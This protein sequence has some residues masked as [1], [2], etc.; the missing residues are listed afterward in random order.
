[1]VLISKSDIDYPSETNPRIAGLITTD[2]KIQ[3]LAKSIETNGLLT[4]VLLYK[5]ENG[6][7][8]AIDGDRRLLALFDV[9]ERDEVDATIK[10]VPD[11]SRLPYLK[12]ASNW[13]RQDFTSIEKGRYL[14]TIVGN[15]M[16]NDNFKIEENW[17]NREIRNEYVRKVS[18]N[19][20]RP[21]ST[22]SR[23]ISLWLQVPRED[24]GIIA[25]NRDELRLG[26]LAPHK[27]TKILAIG[28][29]IG[30]VK[31]TWRTFV[32]ENAVNE[33]TPLDIRTKELGLINR[34]V[35]AGQIKGVSQLQTFRNEKIADDWSQ[36]V[37][38]IRKTEE[39]EAAKLA[40]HLETEISKIYRGCILLGVKHVE[41]LANII[42]G[43][44]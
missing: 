29:K 38:L 14:Y 37:L 15:E 41:E 4:S 6:R 7:Y 17:S 11:L 24:R 35:S 31:G 33:K 10:D 2:N 8:E 16:A 42:Q 36:T 43:S 40:S 30:D 28:R 39:M 13:D 3:E 9:L 27:A 26:K 34:A 19:L 21:V 22:I 25:R 23:L 32:P 12:L 1:M 18:S 20:A 44:L 5:K